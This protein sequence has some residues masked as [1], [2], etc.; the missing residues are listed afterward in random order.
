VPT[1]PAIAGPDNPAKCRRSGHGSTTQ[2]DSSRWRPSPPAYRSL[3][4]VASQATARQ[5]RMRWCGLECWLDQTRA[6]LKRGLSQ[7]WQPLAIGLG[8]RH[9]S[10]VPKLPK[11]SLPPRWPHQHDGG[12]L[13]RPCGTRPSDAR[14]HRHR[15]SRA[16][17]TPFPAYATARV[18]PGSCKH[19]WPPREHDEGAE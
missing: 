2:E 19:R 1:K 15:V 7:A 17:C 14:P 18:L 3:R 5:T 16:S 10:V 12:C 11:Q 9:R 6:G 4:T 13:H 8:S